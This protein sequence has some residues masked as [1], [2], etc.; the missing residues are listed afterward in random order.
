MAQ[1]FPFRALHYNPHKVAPLAHAVTQPYDK[2]TPQMQERYYASSP[3]NLVRVIRGIA[4][5]ADGESA[6]VYTRARDHFRDWIEKGILLPDAAASIYPY[7]QEYSVPGGNGGRMTRRGFIALIRLEDYAERVVH[8]H[9]ETLSGPKADRLNLLRL[10]RAHFGQIFMLY[11]DPPGEVEAAL[12]GHAQ[13]AAWQQAEDEHGTL[14]SVWRVSDPA[15]VSRVSEAM[16]SKKLV[17][18]DGHHRYET[19]LA[20]RNER[21]AGGA[22]DDRAEYVMATL[23]RMETPGLT[24]LPTHRVL[25]GLNGFDWNAFRRA[26]IEWFD[27]QEAALPAV[28]AGAELARRVAQAGERGTAVGAYAGNGRAAVLAVRSPQALAAALPEV[29]PALRALDVVALHRL[30]LERAMKIDAQ[31]VR[32]ERHLHYVREA[33]EAMGAVDKGQADLCFILNPTPME[34]L[35]NTAFDG[36]VMPQKSTDFF[37]KLLSGLTIYWLDNPAGM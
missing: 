14:H 31:A 37:P 29:P 19:A 24:I 16:R 5:P 21:R 8:R 9:E 2:I 6:N 26:A 36:L 23:V 20:Y 33:A 11:S 17:I 30:L 4:H 32:E 27:W 25:H 3:Y 28:D 13:G 22:L 15:T 34:A 10:T 7:H 1:V 35:R 12:A 18:A